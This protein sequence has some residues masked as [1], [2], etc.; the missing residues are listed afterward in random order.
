VDD[1]S[2]VAAGHG[3][4]DGASSAA[5]TDGGIGPAGAFQLEGEDLRVVGEGFVEVGLDAIQALEGNADGE[6]R[7]DPTGE[8]D[9]EAA[10]LVVEGGGES[11]GKARQGLQAEGEAAAGGQ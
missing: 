8:E 10:G 7:A 5:R 4:F 11:F 1:Q 2:A 9:G 3:D 6:G